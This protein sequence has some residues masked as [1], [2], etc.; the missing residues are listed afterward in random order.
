[1]VGLI[2]FLVLDNVVKNV[3]EAFMRILVIRA[4]VDQLL[5]AERASLASARALVGAVADQFGL[6]AGIKFGGVDQGVVAEENGATGIVTSGVLQAE[7]QASVVTALV[8]P[9]VLGGKLDA[10]SNSGNVGHRSSNAGW[11]CVLADHNSS[12]EESRGNNSLEHFV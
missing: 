10:F 7:G 12:K 2:T 8:V 5:L 11:G 3:V 4:A 9:P 1:M 6:L